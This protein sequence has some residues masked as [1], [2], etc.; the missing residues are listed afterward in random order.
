MTTVPLA[1]TG[2]L[3]GTMR[4]FRIAT[5]DESAATAYAPNASSAQINFFIRH[6]LSEKLKRNYIPFTSLATAFLGHRG[7]DAAR[8][9]EFARSGW[10]ELAPRGGGVRIGSLAGPR[11]PSLRRLRGSL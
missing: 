10:A 5:A 3:T 8:T 9:G 1:I 2:P 11:G 4:A 7:L 6:A